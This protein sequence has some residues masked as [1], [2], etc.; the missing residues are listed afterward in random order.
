ML[1]ILIFPGALNFH[2][3]F[4]DVRI[5][6]ENQS[7]L[8]EGYRWDQFESQNIPWMK[9]S[10]NTMILI[11]VVGVICVL[12]NTFIIFKV[13]MKRYGH[14]SDG[15]AMDGQELKMIF[16]TIFCAIMQGILAVQQ[17][18]LSLIESLLPFGFNI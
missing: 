9:N 17:V 1:F 18:Y 13:W 3:F 4:T 16:Y 7:N 5:K 14:A 12:C 8:E 2:F 6:P 10:R 11:C 15:I